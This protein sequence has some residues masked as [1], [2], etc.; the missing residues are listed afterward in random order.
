MSDFITLNKRNGGCPVCGKDNGD[1]RKVEDDDYENPLIICQSYS[2]SYY[3]EVVPGVDGND[4]ICVSN[5]PKC[6]GSGFV[7]TNG[8]NA[9]TSETERLQKA[10]L[11][12]S[13]KERRNKAKAEAQARALAAEE[14][15][16][17]HTAII[18]EL[19]L[20]EED[21]ELLLSKGLTEEEIVNGGFRSVAQWQPVTT[22]L[23]AN[24]PGKGRGNNLAVSEDG[25]LYPVRDTSNLIIGFQVRK[26]K[27]DPK[28]G[29]YSWVSSQI[30]SVRSKEHDELPLSFIDYTGD[31]L[32]PHT[33]I[34]TEG[35][36][37]K[38]DIASREFKAIAFGAAGGNFTP[39]TFKE[40]W[41]NTIQ[42]IANR[43]YKGD[44]SKVDATPVLA[45][46]A[47]FGRNNHVVAQIEKLAK[48]TQEVTG[49][50][51]VVLDWNQASN[52]AVGD[53][54]EVRNISKLAIRVNWSDFREQ[55]AFAF[56]KQPQSVKKK[57]IPQ[58][59]RWSAT[60]LGK[61][62]QKN[63]S[64]FKIENTVFLM[65]NTS[66]EAAAQL[67]KHH[68]CLALA[69]PG[70]DWHNYRESLLEL[71][72]RF[73]PD[74]DTAGANN[75]LQL[76]PSDCRV[77][78]LP[79]AGEI[80]NPNAFGKPWALTNNYS[81][82][83]TLS[84]FFAEYRA[85]YALQINSLSAQSQ[86]LLIET[87]EEQRQEAVLNKKIP[88][89][90]NCKSLTTIA[91]A[92]R[93][94]HKVMLNQ[95]SVAWWGQTR[96]AYAK[97]QKQL[98]GNPIE[99]I[100]PLAYFVREK[101]KY[102]KKWSFQDFH[103][104]H[105]RRYFFRSLLQESKD[106]M[107]PAK[108]AE[109]AAS[110]GWKVENHLNSKQELGEVVNYWADYQP[111]IFAALSLMGSGKTKSLEKIKKDLSDRELEIRLAISK[112]LDDL[113]HRGLP[114]TTDNLAPLLDTQALS[115]W[116]Q[117]K[118]Q[119]KDPIYYGWALG[120]FLLSPR[121][122]LNAQTAERTGIP[123]RQDLMRGSNLGVCSAQCLCPDSILHVSL[124]E[125]TGAT[126]VIDEIESTLRHCFT[127]ST[128]SQTRGGKARADRLKHLE[129]LLN[130]V[131]LTGGRVIILDANLDIST[132]SKIE[133]L[134]QLSL[135]QPSVNKK[136][137]YNEYLL[138]NTWDCEFIYGTQ[139]KPKEAKGFSPP[140]GVNHQDYSA[141][142][143]R[144]IADVKQSK[145]PFV[146]SDNK[147]LLQYLNYHLSQIITDRG[148]L[149]VSG[150]DTG[151]EQKEF[152]KNPD[153]YLADYKPAWVLVSP[154]VESGVSITSDYFYKV[155]GLFFGTLLPNAAM[156]MLGRVRKSVPR[157]VWCVV[158]PNT[159][160]GLKSEGNFDACE[161]GWQFD[162]AEVLRRAA[163][164]LY[165]GIR[166]TRIIGSTLHPLTGSLLAQGI[167]INYN[168]AIA[169]VSAEAKE[170][171]TTNDIWAA[172]VVK[173][174][175]EKFLYRQELL[176]R[177]QAGK[178]QKGARAITHNDSDDLAYDAE[179]TEQWNTTKE[180]VKLRK[181]RAIFNA[182]VLTEEEYEALRNTDRD[183]SEAE[184]YS[185][186]RAYIALSLNNDIT[187]TEE[188][189]YEYYTKDDGRT[190]RALKTA[191]TVD[192]LPAHLK[193]QQKEQFFY[194]K[195]SAR[196][197]VFLGDA[198]AV[199]G[200]Y[201]HDCGLTELLHC[202]FTEA[203]AIEVVESHQDSVPDFDRE[204][205]NLDPIEYI[206]KLASKIGGEV[207]EVDEDL[208]KLLKL[209]K[210]A[211]DMDLKMAKKYR[212]K[213]LAEAKPQFHEIYKAMRQRLV[214]QA[215]AAK[216][217]L[218]KVIKKIKDRMSEPIEIQ[219][220]S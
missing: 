217:K 175:K 154:S 202:Q 83:L 65:S 178:S 161:D 132:L 115:I 52:K 182:Q 53:V 206:E 138:E 59:Y 82:K 141:V 69:I 12:K 140:R 128:M 196:S 136:F 168:K 102:I 44:T 38:P 200:K 7:K 2:G 1:C 64:A 105:N 123:N 110:K 27:K 84:E 73:A 103:N 28:G 10:A 47:G 158:Q 134:L 5:N 95:Y 15:H 167:Q 180:A 116:Q 173:E 211:T 127:S 122:S 34:L 179:F 148:G 94:I 56:N 153:K 125:A 151:K 29:K 60:K 164:K 172:Y 48:L 98:H 216:D 17:I 33:V 207:V 209:K 79:G 32:D 117:Y 143:R 149:I 30:N 183:L 163:Q 171:V 86:D 42:L 144:I 131:L 39:E 8:R 54:D 190:L 210:T 113:D 43:K 142:L 71:L 26:T 74:F 25:I 214:N 57:I 186:I 118:F 3:K 6:H 135:K 112:A 96:P 18:K 177:I 72:K 40:Y 121:R 22:K 191:V 50:Q 80:D 11:R 185:L 208:T 63:S 58:D 198:P 101:S 176:W 145:V 89:Y 41:N 108:I 24:F 45:P 192:E 107:T 201:L 92:L 220:I 104:Q 120:L 170:R 36:R 4:Y 97:I 203:Y 119:N 152:L 106:N 91:D 93:V 219:L 184:R 13:K 81:L 215:I 77:L 193:V 85:G 111:G 187:L 133:D 76:E 194:L 78:Y 88:A 14:R 155:Y 162:K 137:I 100:Y 49:K 213:L 166:A 139:K 218:D 165:Y 67:A 129:E 20:N 212:I 55:Y 19:Q 16:K 156:Q 150:E 75:K 68:N 174:N 204:L 146:C 169:G 188:I 46:D 99:I 66:Q 189:I 21:K 147:N 9:I 130:H 51:L 124:T 70:F 195:A 90:F 35:V 114:H 199:S 31:D 23:L 160:S 87:L 181:A 126:V 205:S 37:V 62:P 61:K 197:S 159:N 109:F 157:V